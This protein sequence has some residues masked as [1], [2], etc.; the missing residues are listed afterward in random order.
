VTKGSSHILLMVPVDILKDNTLNR[1]IH[2]KDIPNKVATHLQDIHLKGVTHPK[3]VTH[4]Q[5]IHPKAV[6][7]LKGV[8]HNQDTHHKAATHQ[9]D[10]PLVPTHPLVILVHPLH[11]MEGMERAWEGC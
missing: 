10:I 5:D 8:T 7:H 9:Q 2:R 1:A 11:I 4:N 6:T 3:A